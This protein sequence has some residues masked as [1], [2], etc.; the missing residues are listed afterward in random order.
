MARVFVLRFAESD[1][2]SKS[3]DKI[4]AHIEREVNSALSNAYED[5]DEV[6]ITQ[7]SVDS[8]GSI[9]HLFTIHYMKL[10]PLKQ[11]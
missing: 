1:Y 3:S 9:V 6:S 4:A 2:P 8:G 11:R 5:Y 10:K 7:S